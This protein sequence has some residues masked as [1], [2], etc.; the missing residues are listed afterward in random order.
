MS[1]MIIAPQKDQISTQGDPCW[2]P[3]EFPL[4]GRLKL[5]KEQLTK[6]IEKIKQEESRHR[7]DCYRKLKN[8]CCKSLHISLFFDGT[9]NNEPNDTGSTPPHPSNV[10]KLYHASAP[11]NRQANESGFYAYYIPGVGTPFPQIGTYDYYSSGLQF[12]V[13]GEDR[14]NW[15]LVQ[16]CNTLHHTVTKNFIGNGH[17]K[18]TVETMNSSDP[19]RQLSR[20]AAIMAATSPTASLT[21]LVKSAK[22]T[23]QVCAF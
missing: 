1:S 10:A 2:V 23:K 6:N 22:V 15:G 8:S 3:P 19:S 12:A 18:K 7:S 11:E 9:N 21:R 17:M 4:D 14:I 13:G 20:N 16:L 5:T